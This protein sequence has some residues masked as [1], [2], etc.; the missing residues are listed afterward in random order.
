MATVYFY[1]DINM[2]AATVWYGTV[3]E[4]DAGQI[5]ISNGVDET[6]YTGNFSYDQY[7]YVYGTLTGMAEIENGAYAYV[8]TGLNVNAT[9][10]E[11]YI[12]S[13]NAG[14]F[15][16]TALVGNDQFVM[17]TT[18]T[19]I[20]D[21][22]AGYNT[23]YETGPRSSYVWTV[24]AN[25]SNQTGIGENDTL[26]NIQGAY[27]SDGF[28][29]FTN[30]V[31]TPNPPGTSVIGGTVLGNPGPSWHAV[32]T[33]DFNGDGHGDILWQNDNGSVVD[34]LVNASGT[35][36]IGGTVL[37]NPGPSWHA[38][39]TGDF[40]GDG[41][42]DILWQNDNG[43][44]VDWLVNASGTGLIGG[45]V[46]GN[47]GPSWHVVATGD[48]NGDGH[49]DILWQNDDGSVADWLMNPTGMSLI[50]GTVLG[51]SGPSWHAVATGDFNGDGHSDILWQNDNG[52]VVDWLMNSTGN[53]LIGGSTLGN[54]P[55]SPN[56]GPTW[57]AKATGDFNG[58]GHSDIL[59]QNDNGGVVDWLIH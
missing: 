55:G 53:G 57:H 28:L 3:I 40:N 30:G 58:D 33:G 2:H 10:A 13:G 17:A 26:Y 37:G 50:G 21:G 11:Y 4:H 7:G 12:Q 56:P 47:P 16:Q 25:N 20:I 8:A 45:T 59:W 22:Y 36:L 15:L 52:T 29:N 18:G 51:N 24:G 9:V 34:W 42:S 23:V 6:I 46:L 5:V 49:A 44:V 48:F 32:A 35:G 27:F 19:H 39:A 41:H 43:T 31:F 54:N 14:A 38:V 1:K